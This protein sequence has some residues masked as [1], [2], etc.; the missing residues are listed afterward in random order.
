MTNQSTQEPK[1]QVY[2]GIDVERASAA[3]R[4]ASIVARRRAL[5]NR[6][7]VMIYRDGEMVW[8]TEPERI[9]PPG[10]EVKICECGRVLVKDLVEDKDNYNLDPLEKSAFL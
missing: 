4:R 10:V 8:E 7:G 3:M 2:T 1:E 5:E 6:G 9:F